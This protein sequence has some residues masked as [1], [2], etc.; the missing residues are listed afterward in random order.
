M[1]L[2]MLYTQVGLLLWLDYVVFTLVSLKLKVCSR[3]LD[4]LLCNSLIWTSLSLFVKSKGTSVL[5][6]LAQ[7]LSFLKV[8]DSL[9][10]T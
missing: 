5:F 8:A 7:C 4:L 2:M 3:L 1:I 6:A 9:M 10:K